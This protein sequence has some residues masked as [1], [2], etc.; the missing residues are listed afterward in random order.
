MTKRLFRSK[1]DRILLGVCGGMATYFNIDPV[2]VRLLWVL[3]AI[4]GGAGILAY[5]VAAVI[6][7]L[8]V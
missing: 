3:F 8:E 7:P 5:L 1:N 6:M 2:I 4:M